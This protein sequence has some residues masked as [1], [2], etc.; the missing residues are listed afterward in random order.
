MITILGSTG[1]VGR[2]TI[3]V[4]AELG[5]KIAAL[6]AKQSVD[7]VERQA[8]ACRPL[9]VAMEDDSAAKVLKD[10]LFGTRTEVLSG[11]E[12][13]CK[14][15]TCKESDIVVSAI[16]GASG[17]LPTIAGVE[18]K[19]QI[20][21]AN[22]ET[23]VAAGGV[24]MPLAKESGVPI[25]PVDS[26][27]SAIFQCLMASCGSKVDRILL[28]AS[29]GPFFGKTQHQ[30]ESVTVEDALKHPSWSMGAKITVDSATLMNK[31]LEIIEAMWLFD[32]PE[33]KIEVIVHKESIIHSMV[34]FEDGVVMAQL[35]LAD[36]KTPIRLAL[37]WPKRQKAAGRID[38]KAMT[39]LSIAAPDEETFGCLA[40]CRQAARTGGV[41][42]AALS[43]AN[44][45]AVAAF[46][47]GKIKF[48]DIERVCRHVLN[49]TS[50]GNLTIDGILAADKAAREIAKEVT[51]ECSR[52]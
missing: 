23:L 2:Q 47:A 11:V 21:L 52:Q 29:G 24:V 10:R 48:L 19:K 12:G 35:G 16:V 49:K 15:A 18:A 42:P 3:E 30:L 46:L 14:A 9:L 43:A 31:G 5:I 17:I 1:S 39:G 45:V 6:A 51:Y 37:T 33:D 20:A 13:V 50:V 26:E 40:L 32:L 28:T 38:F 44:E 8:R 22:K 4:A 34:E 27:H 41:A 7:A 25:I 36:M